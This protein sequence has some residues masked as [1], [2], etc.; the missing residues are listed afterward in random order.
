MNI[1]FF[2]NNYILLVTLS[3]CTVHTV[4]KVVVP[5]MRSRT[6]KININI[7]PMVKVSE[8]HNTDAKTVVPI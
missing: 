3:D 7:L 5:D 2:Q 4:L 6:I 8:E 1:K